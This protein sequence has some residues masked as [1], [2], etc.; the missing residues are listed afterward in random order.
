MYGDEG[1]LF[2]EDIFDPLPQGADLAD[3]AVRALR[4]ECD[5]IYVMPSI[6]DVIIRF[7]RRREWVKSFQMHR[8]RLPELIRYL[9]LF[10]SLERS[11]RDRVEEGTL[12][13]KHENDEVVFSV[14]V[15]RTSIGERVHLRLL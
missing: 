12:K 3:I 10:A 7:Y 9:K 4:L 8:E 13:I 5:E 14:R 11:L 1:F 2:W 15:V 6:E